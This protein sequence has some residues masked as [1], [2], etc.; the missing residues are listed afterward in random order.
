MELGTSIPFF[1]SSLHSYLYYYSCADH[2]PVTWTSAVHVSIISEEFILFISTC[3]LNSLSDIS[4]NNPKKFFP[5]PIRST[6]I[7]TPIILSLKI[8][9]VRQMSNSPQ[10]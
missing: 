9:K 2:K 6:S 5:T 7:W 4:P 8:A 3:Q 1:H 10:P